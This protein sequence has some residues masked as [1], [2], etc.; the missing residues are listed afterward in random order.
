M[1][2]P[3]R[4]CLST[5]ICPQLAVP[6]N[7]RMLGRSLRVGH[8]VHFVCDPGFRLAGSETRACRHNRTWS[9]TQPFCRSE[10]E[11][12]WGVMGSALP[13]GSSVTLSYGIPLLC[14]EAAATGTRV[15]QGCTSPDDADEFLLPRY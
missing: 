11:R 8:E 5:E 15:G 3:T 14:P 6:L 10:V 1:S 7:G 12:G 4:V 2:I 13:T 9:G